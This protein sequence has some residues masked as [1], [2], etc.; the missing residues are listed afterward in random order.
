VRAGEE[1]AGRRPVIDVLVHNAGHVDF[2]PLAQYDDAHWDAMVDV[3]VRSTMQLT[4]ALLPALRRST[5]AAIVANTSVDGILGYPG[6]PV[7][8]A[9]KAALIGLVRSTAY[10]LGGDGIRVNCVAPGGIDTSMTR[11][12]R[13]SKRVVEEVARLTPLRRRGTPEEVARAI[14]FLA[15]DDASFVTGEV[16]VVDGGRTVVTPGALGPA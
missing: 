4:H 6:A 10:E 3:N 9:A 14:L 8:S 13:F 2:V 5:A 16:L 15:S 7:Y 11:Q 12:A 1:L